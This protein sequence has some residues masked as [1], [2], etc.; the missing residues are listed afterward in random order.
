MTQPSDNL[1]CWKHPEAFSYNMLK[2]PASIPSASMHAQQPASPEKKSP[3]FESSQSGLTQLDSCQSTGV[4]FIDSQQ[5]DQ[6]QLRGDV[7]EIRS[8]AATNTTSPGAT[9]K[10]HTRSSST[11]AQFFAAGAFFS[12]PCSRVGLVSSSPFAK[13]ATLSIGHALQTQISAERHLEASSQSQHM[14]S[15]RRRTLSNLNGEL[16][17]SVSSLLLRPILDLLTIHT[18]TA[19]NSDDDP[20]RI[21][22]ECEDLPSPIYGR[23]GSGETTSHDYAGNTL[24]YAFEASA[25]EPFEPSSELPVS[26]A[27]DNDVSV[28]DAD[29]RSLSTS[30][31]MVMESGLQRKV[32]AI[33]SSGEVIDTPLMNLQEQG[34]VV[35]RSRGFD[36]PTADELSVVTTCSRVETEHDG[37]SPRA[38]SASL[39]ERYWQPSI[40]TEDLESIRPRSRSDIVE[41]LVMDANADMDPQDLICTSGLTVTAP[42]EPYPAGGECEQMAYSVEE[43]EPI[44]RDKDLRNRLW[45]TGVLELDLNLDLK[46]ERIQDNTAFGSK[47]ENNSIACDESP[48]QDCFCEAAQA[49]N[50]PSAS[51]ILQGSVLNAAALFPIPE[52]PANGCDSAY[53]KFT[54][55]Y[56][57]PSLPPSPELDTASSFKEPRVTEPEMS[58]F[59]LPPL[60]PSPVMDPASGQCTF[61]NGCIP[62]DE[63]P[64]LPPSPELPSKP[65]SIATGPASLVLPPLPPS[66][67]ESICT[68]KS[69]EIA[70]TKT[71][72]RYWSQTATRL[73]DQEQVLTTRID[74]LIQEMAQV[75][76]KCQE[77]E[78][79]LL[80]KETMVQE[81]RRELVK[82]QEFGFVSVQEA[83]LSI[84]EK[85]LLESALEESWKELGVLR[86]A[87]VHQQ[88]VL[89]ESLP[90]QE[91]TVSAFEDFERKNTKA[92]AAAYA[93]PLPSTLQAHNPQA[94]MSTPRIL[95]TM[96][97]HKRP[98]RSTFLQTL[99]KMLCLALI[100]TMALVSTV[101]LLYGQQDHLHQIFQTL[102]RHTS[103][104]YFDAKYAYRQFAAVAEEVFRHTQMLLQRKQK[105]AEDH[106]HS[107]TELFWTAAELWTDMDMTELW[108][109]LQISRTWS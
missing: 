86:E 105:T 14:V 22:S 106:V 64:P 43:H 59:L 48:R 34:Y 24:H 98:T 31:L 100:C 35:V 71:Q 78:L 96:P 84:Q 17:P 60:P 80:E 97:V 7:Q 9:S 29:I 25:V 90:Q 1:P 27:P 39:D 8:A 4:T 3:Q 20:S 102:S 74:V 33:A 46:Q 91:V 40:S 28:V 85:C 56:Y 89:R 79:G 53:A 38:M 87:W 66:P 58:L 68:P 54:P 47:N 94:E 50:S 52:S 45:N 18:A 6:K 107:M 93:K 73:R 70:F 10:R 88:Q 57:L 81:L 83:A 104:W 63:L 11:L 65:L 15:G 12:P 99:V 32:G 77:T 13:R 36:D 108:Q 51:P 49:V 76:E 37:E 103:R 69:L 5:A 82:E 23:Y 92:L 95:V 44:I 55:F 2:A 42:S 61:V 72:L 62:V 109:S 19:E 16:Q 21:A 26:I 75:L 30:D 101:V 41:D 67:A